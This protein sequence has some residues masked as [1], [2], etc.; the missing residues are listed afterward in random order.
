MRLVLL[1]CF[2]IK[3]VSVSAESITLISDCL[4]TGSTINTV[5]TKINLNTSQYDVKLKTTVHTS[6]RMSVIDSAE[7]ETSLILKQHNNTRRIKS[8]KESQLLE[9]FAVAL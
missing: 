3:L 7:T 6:Q 4:P 2:K 8:T 9:T 5:E 1:C